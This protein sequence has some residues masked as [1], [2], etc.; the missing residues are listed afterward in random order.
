MAVEYG[1]DI[2]TGIIL[3]KLK[4]TEAVENPN[5][6]SLRNAQSL[7]QITSNRTKHIIDSIKVEEITKKASLKQRVKQ[8]DDHVFSTNQVEKTN[9]GKQKKFSK[10]EPDSSLK[11]SINSRNV[12]ID[13]QYRSN[14][15]D[16]KLESIINSRSISREQGRQTDF[17]NK[18]YSRLETKFNSP[19]NLLP[20]QDILTIKPQKPLNEDLVGVAA[21]SK[22]KLSRSQIEIK[23]SD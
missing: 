7:P 22:R 6:K 3:R 16:L 20:L 23:E 17:K 9:I 10:L 18:R 14:N 15:A 12:N 4:R 11:Q 13:I 2:N 21:I 5:N 19:K 8:E 1:I